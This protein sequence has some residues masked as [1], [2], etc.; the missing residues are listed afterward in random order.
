MPGPATVASLKVYLG[1]DPASS[2]DEQAMTVAVDAGNDLVAALRPDLVVDPTTG[3]PLADWPARAHQAANVQAAQ[4][5]GGRGSVQGIAAFSDVG[6][7]MIPRLHPQVRA[8]LE[9]GEYQRST[10]A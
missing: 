3:L 4:S 1:L 10:V 9:L 5:Y 7:S 8:L 6:V 2:V